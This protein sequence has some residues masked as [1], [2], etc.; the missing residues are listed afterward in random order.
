M[1]HNSRRRV[2]VMTPLSV[3]MPAATN[4]STPVEITELGLS[5]L[6]SRVLVRGPAG[7]T[8]TGIYFRLYWGESD[9]YD[10]TTDPSTVPDEN[11]VFEAGDATAGALTIVGSA[12]A[13]DYDY[14]VLINKG[15]APYDLKNGRK[16]WLSMYS[17]AASASDEDFT[18]GLEAVDV[19]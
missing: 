5:G 16:L 15:G 10:A 14:N 3:D 18:I 8:V 7:S 19:T 2:E 13:A 12:T 1:A 4:W 17:A 11:L 6:L 9:E